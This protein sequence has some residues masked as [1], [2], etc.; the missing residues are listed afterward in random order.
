[1]SEQRYLFHEPHTCK[2]CAKELPETYEEDFC[3][4]C[5]EALL[6][7]EVREFIRE[8]DVNEYQVAEKFQIPVGQVKLWIKEGRIEYKEIGDNVMG[9]RYCEKCGAKIQFG[10]ICTKCLRAESI[11]GYGMRGKVYSNG[12][13]RFVDSKPPKKRK[14]NTLKDDE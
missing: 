13:M 5:K 8:N 7:D 6:F 1:M 2:R 10:T 12:E 14:S 11:G 9:G 4:Q 3:P